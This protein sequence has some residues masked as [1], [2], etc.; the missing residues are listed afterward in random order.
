VLDAIYGPVGPLVW[1]PATLASTP[2]GAIAIG[3]LMS[4]VLLLAPVI[5][6]ARMEAGRHHT[7]LAATIVLGVALQLSSPALPVV[8]VHTD[9]PAIAF[10]TLALAC[11]WTEGQRRSTAWLWAGAAFVIASAGSK[12][13]MA[14]LL[15]AWPGWIAATS[16][17][18]AGRRA[19]VALAITGAAA[20]G[21]VLLAFDA[22]SMIDATVLGPLR[23]PW[24]DD[25]LPALLI[26]FVELV[27]R[28]LPVAVL[29]AAAAWTV[30]RRHSSWRRALR[31]ERWTF[32]LALAVACVPASLLGGAKVG[33]A[34]NALGFTIWFVWV[35]LI[36]AMAASGRR[37][38][39]RCLL[40]SGAAALL[41]CG[42][43]ARLAP[44]LVS[45]PEIVRRTPST[46]VAF[47]AARAAPGTIY[48]PYRPV[49]GMM[50]DGRPNH[51]DPGLYFRELEGRRIDEVFVR[52]HLPPAMNRVAADRQ[53][54]PHSLN[55]LPRYRRQILDPALPGWIVLTESDLLPDAPM[56]ARTVTEGALPDA[57]SVTAPS[58]SAE[59]ALADVRVTV[60][61]RSRRPVVQLDAK[62]PVS[63]EEVEVEVLLRDRAGRQVV[64]LAAT[65]APAADGRLAA[66]WPMY[67]DLLRAAKDAAVVVR[68]GRAATG[69]WW[70]LSA[71]DVRQLV[72][73]S[74]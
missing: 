46:D 39:D 22:V 20:L 41:A 28:M 59:L 32:P 25:T 36:A 24:I 1:L 37:G 64:T 61:D 54:M 58:L 31:G 18:A 16:G 66:R 19:F 48:F 70:R 50:A 45:L 26:V 47:E 69:P 52:A 67:S 9:V 55:Y 7:L 38:S 34:A 15:V 5:W 62:A 29:L 63:L 60:A 68:G 65:L 27:R 14:P 21:V 23:H 8:G 40:L 43:A 33:G 73:A 13:V 12:Q 6:I 2:T 42:L 56:P 3:L 4:V 53:L 71:Q 30:R 57:I 10:A 72:Q 51:V 74:R 35:A 44:D 17:W 11:A 49:V